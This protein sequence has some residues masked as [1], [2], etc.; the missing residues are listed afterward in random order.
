MTPILLT[1]PA[2]EPI[3]V[4][5]TK[6]FLRVEHDDDDQLIAALIAGARSHIEA[7]TQTALI[8]QNWRMVLD[9][10]P[11][12]GRITVRPGPLQTVNAARVFDCN[13]DPATINSQTI[14][15]DLGASRLA[16]VPWAVPAPGRIA[17]GIEI[18]VTVGFGDEADD[19]PESLIQAIRMVVAHWYENRGLMG[20]NQNASPPASVAALIAPYRMFSI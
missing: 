18:D 10:W 12:H 9:A 2:I 1:G 3:S 4:E 16:F 15:T 7:Q 14:V 20:G 19:V 5:E 13:G 6:I 8:T 17:A 11:Q